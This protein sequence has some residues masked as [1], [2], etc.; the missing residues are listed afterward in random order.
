M[1]VANKYG[2]LGPFILGL[3]VLVSGL[4]SSSAQTAGSLPPIKELKTATPGKRVFQEATRDKPIVI[5]T[6]KDAAKYFEP[7][8]LGKLLKQVD[9][10]KQ[11]VF[12]FAWRGSGQDQ[13]SYTVQESF[14]EQVVFKYKPGRTRDLRPHVRVYALRNNVKWKGK[15]A[16]PAARGC[17]RSTRTSPGTA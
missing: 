2:I 15:P 1:N 12:I 11:V 5:T 7:N 4:S 14:P 9:L 3:I 10:S 6:Q 17:G 8:Q 13:I 16:R